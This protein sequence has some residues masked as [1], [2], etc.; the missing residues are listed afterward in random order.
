MQGSGLDGYSDWKGIDDGDSW[1]GLE[2]MMSVRM[3]EWQMG[4]VACIGYWLVLERT[5]WKLRLVKAQD[6]ELVERMVFWVSQP[7]EG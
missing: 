7:F 1:R 3:L 5:I 2:W 6:E 4:G